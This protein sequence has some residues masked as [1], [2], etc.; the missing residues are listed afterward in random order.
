MVSINIKFGYTDKTYE[1]SYPVGRAITILLDRLAITD[2]NQ[3]TQTQIFMDEF[4]ADFSNNALK[5][6]ENDKTGADE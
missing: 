6:G 2:K 1:V 4:V 3:K 5:G